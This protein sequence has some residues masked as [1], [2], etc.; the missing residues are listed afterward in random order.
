MR[1]MSRQQKSATPEPK[2]PREPT[3]DLTDV[4]PI[5]EK[6]RRLTQWDIKPPGYE[7]VTAEQAKL[8]GMYP[9]PGAPR[10][11]QDP[12]RLQALINQP[13][14]SATNTALK[15]SNSRQ[16]K[17]LFVYNIP[18]DATDETIADF[19]NLQLNGLN[20]VR[21]IDPCIKASVNAGHTVA[22]LEFKNSEDATTALA[23]DGVKMEADDVHMDGT[24]GGANGS[25]T[26]GLSIKRPKDYIAP[27]VNDDKD[28]EADGLPSMV[29]DSQYKI[30]VTHL[31]T[32]LT[33]EQVRELVQ[34]FGELK[35]FVLVADTSSGQ[36]RGIAFCEYKDAE[37]ATE[38]AVEGL[39]HMELGD[40]RLELQRACVGI[41]QA[42]GELSVSAMS[43]MAAS[44]NE[45][46]LGRVL[47]LLNMV[48]P[49][50]LMDNDEYEGKIS[51]TPLPMHRTSC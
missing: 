51:L 34:A 6:K 25:A 42:A 23:L 13:A 31:P 4:V 11:Q 3:P 24:N 41:K 50:E 15:P 14:G 46:D 16:S 22:V 35:S 19:F 17:R 12:S 8:S 2:K 47:C 32:Y 10:Q 40:S 18:A 7:N 21:G 43:M 27:T 26:Q 37:D 44:T 33:E 45:A 39:N 28:S 48:T 29:P 36:S 9:L 38:I 5:L 49:E 30:V 20:V 1:Q